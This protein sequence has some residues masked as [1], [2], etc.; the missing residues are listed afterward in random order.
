MSNLNSKPYNMKEES[1]PYIMKEKSKLPRT[2]D[3]ESKRRWTNS[4]NGYYN[5]IASIN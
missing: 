2:E 4:T 3:V 1:K 5:K